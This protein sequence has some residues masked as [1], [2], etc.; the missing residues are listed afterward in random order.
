MAVVDPRAKTLKRELGRDRAGSGTKPENKTGDGGG[1]DGGG[2]TKPQSG[3]AKKY[4]YPLD[5]VSDKSDYLM[6]QVV[7]YTAPGVNLSGQT[8][9]FKEAIQAGSAPNRP[10]LSEAGNNLRASDSETKLRQNAKEKTLAY[11]IL[12]MPPQIGA[13][14]EVGWDSGS[15]NA[16]GAAVAALGQEL[17][18]N[19]SGSPIPTLGGAQ[20]AFSVLTNFGRSLGGQAGALP[21]L[22]GDFLT[23]MMVNLIPGVQ[24]SP[25]EFFARNRGIAINPNMEFLFRGPKLRNFRFAFTLI[26]RNQKEA[27]EI[28][29]ITRSLKQYMS[30][31]KN[32]EAFGA[33]QVF[34][35]F[36]STPDVFKITYMSGTK[37]HEYLN[38]FKYCAMTNLSV[39]YTDAAQGYVSYEDGAPIS[40]GLAMDF[41]ELTPIYAED[42]DSPYAGKGGF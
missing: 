41:T 12:P 6:L 7:K 42:Y 32:I 23:S 13:N 20:Q 31:K 9:A 30:P 4:R 17:M 35:A 25:G 36:L 19:R 2:G 1:G 24:I 37:P 5:V 15:I 33:N 28:R 26:A 14:N 21:G 29:E 22:A 16:A 10:E 27:N 8:Q 18:A 3:K 38:A 40:V 39:N 11:Y 34:G